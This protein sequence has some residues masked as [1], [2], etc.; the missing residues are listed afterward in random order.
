MSFL[1]YPSICKLNLS[2]KFHLYFVDLSDIELEFIIFIQ[3]KII[4]HEYNLCCKKYVVTVK[5]KCCKSILLRPV[6]VHLRMSYPLW[7]LNLHLYQRFWYSL[8]HISSLYQITPKLKI[9]VFIKSCMQ[10]NNTAG[11]TILSPPFCAKFSCTQS[12]IY[13]TLNIGHRWVL[14]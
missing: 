13:F 5:I 8:I 3:V 14:Q 10:P 1:H 6:F 12:S 4:I 9:L 2:S 7:D 11:S